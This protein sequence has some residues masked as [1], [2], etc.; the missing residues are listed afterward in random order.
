M[1]DIF[2]EFDNESL[3][4]L[5]VSYSRDLTCEKFLS[6][7]LYIQK[8]INYIMEER[9]VSDIDIYRA[10]FIFNFNF[11]RMNGDNPML[12]FNKYLF[13]RY[14]LA[15]GNKEVI[16]NL[17]CYQNEK[18]ILEEIEKDSRMGYVINFFMPPELRGEITLEIEVPKIYVGDG[19]D[20]KSVV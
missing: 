20:R 4:E 16:D 2:E 13:K 6:T 12:P 18:V 9:N 17:N 11:D 7:R 3:G 10:L 15:G 14:F 8:L 19:L 5:L 1:H